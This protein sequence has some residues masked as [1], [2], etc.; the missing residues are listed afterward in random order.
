VTGTLIDYWGHKLSAIPISI[1]SAVAVTDANGAF[2]VPNV[3]RTYDVSLL[4]TTQ[5]LGSTANYGWVFQGLTRRDPTLQI[6]RGLPDRFGE[7][8]LHVT[9]VVFPLPSTQSLAVA[10]A[11]PDG[12][13]NT[14]L[15]AA[16]TDYLSPAWVGPTTSQWAAH[17]LLWAFAGTQNLPTGYLAHSARI[18]SLNTATAG[19]VTFDLVHGG[20]TPVIP[21]GT[22]TG[23]TTRASST[24]PENS[25]FVRFADGPAIQVVRDTAPTGTFSYTV[26][27]L[28]GAA[29]TVAASTGDSSYP[30]YELA[31][32]DDLAAGQTNVALSVPSAPTLVGPAAGAT[33]VTGTTAFRWS[34]GAAVRILAVASVP[35]Y[36]AVF[37]VTSQS[38]AT[39]PSFPAASFS[40]PANTA[41]EWYVE[42][43]GAFATVDAATGSQ[44]MLDPLAYGRPRGSRRGNGTYTETEHRQFTTAP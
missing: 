36:D 41:F 1:G 3:S 4:L 9:N 34:G 32:R 29:I 40:L 26:P 21:A 15:D 20:T 43:H 37:V 2:S 14:T 24:S 8:N 27:T 11:G 5:R 12:E 35:T 7:V 16:N 17:G 6:Y 33:A 42:T 13:F 19:D 39:I 30:P 28:A 25:V 23:S 18:T 22:L 38:Q 31:Y 44:G 10:F